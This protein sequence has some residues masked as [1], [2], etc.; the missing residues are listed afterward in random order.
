MIVELREYHAL[1]G[2]RQ[3]WV[4]YMEDV[5]IPFQQSKGM[6]I[7]G[8][9]VGSQDDH[10]YVWI[11]TFAS[12]SERVRLYAAVFETP[13]WEDEMSP[14]VAQML[15]RERIKVTVLEPTPGSPIGQ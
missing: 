9:F 1:P 6:S 11:R 4:D 2:E 15:D 13:E 7:A 12:E 5:I 8:S 14:R 3:N 10:T